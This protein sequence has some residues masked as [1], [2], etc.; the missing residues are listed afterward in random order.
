MTATITTD[1][2]AVHIRI[3]V[4]VRIG[5]R[6]RGVSRE[7][8]ARL[9]RLSDLLGTIGRP[10]PKRIQQP[11]QPGR[12]PSDS[13]NGYRTLQRQTQT[14]PTRGNHGTGVSLRE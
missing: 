8:V 14:Q 1:A 7:L 5:P 10:K 6:S 2:T 9:R 11:T 12:N 13:G 3:A 4:A